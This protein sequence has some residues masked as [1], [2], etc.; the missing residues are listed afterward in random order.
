MIAVG[1]PRGI[2]RLTEMFDLGLAVV[3]ELDVVDGCRPG[4]RRSGPRVSLDELAA[5]L[6]EQAGSGCSSRP[7]ESRRHTRIAIADQRQSAER[8]PGG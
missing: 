5:G 8:G 6:E 2:G 1:P 4:P 3:G 7:P